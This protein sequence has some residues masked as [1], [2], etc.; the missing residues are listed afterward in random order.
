MDN[1]K[2][3]HLP[4]AGGLFDQHPQFIE[5]VRYIFNERNAYREK[6]QSEREA[7]MSRKN[8]GVAGGRRG[9]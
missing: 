8:R 3:S 1:M 7:E 9:R 6:K 5:E 4:V 2:W